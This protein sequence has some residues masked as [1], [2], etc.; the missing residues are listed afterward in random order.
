[1]SRRRKKRGLFDEF[2]GGSLFRDVERMFERMEEGEEL[3]T[4]YSIRVTQDPQGTKVYA[5]A[6]KNTDVTGLRRQLQQRYPGAEIHIEGGKP[7]IRE[8]STK[9]L[10]PERKGRKT[11]NNDGLKAKEGHFSL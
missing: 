6:G 4:G 3:G 7:L 1:M 10:K 11:C 8:I 5:K 9:P 2:F